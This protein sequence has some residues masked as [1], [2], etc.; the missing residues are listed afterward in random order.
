MS[1]VNVMK[2]KMSEGQYGNVLHKW[3]EDQNE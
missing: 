2:T 1:F 3:Y